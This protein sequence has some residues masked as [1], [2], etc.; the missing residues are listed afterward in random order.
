MG[1]PSPA[2]SSHRGRR[3]V[4]DIVEPLRWRVPPSR[5]MGSARPCRGTDCG[6]CGRGTGR[7]RGIHRQRT[8]YCRPNPGSFRGNVSMRLSFE[9]NFIFFAFVFAYLIF[10][11]FSFHI[12]IWEFRSEIINLSLYQIYP[13]IYHIRTYDCCFCNCN[14][15]HVPALLTTVHFSVTRPKN[16]IMTTKNLEI[17]KWYH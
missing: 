7:G 17:P 6:Y 4:P 2:R 11:F 12:E 13:W 3:S 15:F 10:D 16:E 8:C 5:P 14:Q 9:A 1:V